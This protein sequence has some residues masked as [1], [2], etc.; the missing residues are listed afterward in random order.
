LNLL[1]LLLFLYETI[2]DILMMFFI[3]KRVQNSILDGY[4]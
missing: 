4:P 3:K 2:L 1:F